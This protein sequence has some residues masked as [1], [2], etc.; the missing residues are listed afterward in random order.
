MG[1]VHSAARGQDMD[2]RQ[3]LRGRDNGYRRTDIDGLREE[4][5]RLRQLVIQLSKLV[6]KNVVERK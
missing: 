2:F 6:I 5:A 4:N 1:Q 3:L